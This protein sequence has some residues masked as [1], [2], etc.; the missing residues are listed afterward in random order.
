MADQTIRGLQEVIE[1]DAQADF[2]DYLDAVRYAQ[3][4]PEFRVTH[5]IGI[6]LVNVIFNSHGTE[7]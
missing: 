2:L 1:A 6:F 3:V 5:L 7:L 4:A